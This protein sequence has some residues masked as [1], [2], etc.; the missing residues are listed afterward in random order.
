MYEKKY[1]NEVKNLFFQGCLCKMPNST[2]HFLYMVTKNQISLD[3]FKIVVDL[4]CL[5]VYIG[6]VRYE[7]RVEYI[8]IVHKYLNTFKII[9]NLFVQNQSSY[10]LRI[11][12]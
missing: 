4:G 5:Y 3:K 11:R 6:H 7:K 2:N 10:Y 12:L 1:N 9:Y 8:I